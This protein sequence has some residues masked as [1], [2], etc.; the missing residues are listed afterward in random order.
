[1]ATTI[2]AISF[3]AICLTLTTSYKVNAVNDDVTKAMAYANEIRE[4]TMSL[5]F[6]DPQMNN[7]SSP[8]SEEGIKISIDDI[9]DFYSPGGLKIAPPIR[10]PSSH[11]PSQAP[12]VIP[13]SQD[14]S[15]VEWSQNLKLKWIDP[16]NPKR[17]V[18]AGQ[19]NLILIECTIKKTVA[20]LNKSEDIY[21]TSWIVRNK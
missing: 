2:V 5:P 12:E 18:G 3:T 15:G 16:N 9:D 4:Y 13:G 6:C 10:R 21:T 11:A 14:I 20:G 19:S 17:T 7:P 8:G 1:M